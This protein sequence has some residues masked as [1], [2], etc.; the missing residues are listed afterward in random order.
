MLMICL[1]LFKA[2]ILIYCPFGI[3]MLNFRYITTEYNHPYTQFGVEVMR[4]STLFGMF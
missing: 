3:N 4:G 1:L 2:I